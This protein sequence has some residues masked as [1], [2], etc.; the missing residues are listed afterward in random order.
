MRFSVFANESGK[1]CRLRA[2]QKRSSVGRK[3]RV[4]VVVCYEALQVSL[5][6]TK[7]N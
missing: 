2:S 4:A 6:H 5:S 3:I 1:I 7:T